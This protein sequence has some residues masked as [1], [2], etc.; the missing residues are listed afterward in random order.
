M[1]RDDEVA[2]EQQVQGRLNAP[3]PPRLTA[4][5][6]ADIESIVLR[7]LDEDDAMSVIQ[8]LM[9]AG[10]LIVNQRWVEE[11]IRQTAEKAVRQIEEAIGG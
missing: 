6:M 2:D 7:T 4:E 9:S 10:Y 3:A 1:P 5:E 11:L 8:D